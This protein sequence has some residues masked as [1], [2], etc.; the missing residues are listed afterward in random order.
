MHTR[1]RLSGVTASLTCLGLGLAMTSAAAFAAND[2]EVIFTKIPGHPSSVIPGAL[3]LDGL[4]AFAEFRHMNQL[5]GSPDGS[6]WLMTAR[7]QQGSELETLLM[8]GDGADGSV[9]AQKNQPVH[10]GVPGEVYDFF[11]SGVGRFNDNNDFAFSARAMNGVA[12]H[13]QKVI[14]VIAGNAEIVLQQGDPYFGLEDVPGNPS[15]DELVGNSVGSVH[16]LNDG[17][18]GVHDNTIQNIHSSRRPA[19]FYD[20][21]MFHQT[22]VT[23][24][25]G[26]DGETLF[27]WDTISFNTFYTT[28]N[29]SPISLG[30]NDDERW[31]AHGRRSEQPLPDRVF[32]VDGQIVLETGEQI[33]GEPNVVENIFS[34]DL[35]SN[36]DWYVRGDS[37]GG[38]RVWAIRNGQVVARTSDPIP[39][40][41]ERW[42]TSFVHF[43]GNNHGD[44]M[45]IG[46]TDHP[47]NTRD[48]VIVVNGDVVV[49]SGD[50]ID[51]SGNGLFDDDVFIGRNNPDAA[52]FNGQAF[53]SDDGYVYFFAMLRDSEGNEYNTNPPFSTP[54]SFLRVKVDPTPTC[55][56]DLN[57][58]GVVNVSDLLQL[59]GVWGPCTD[60]V[61]DITG[62]GVVDVSDLLLL[63]SN[64]GECD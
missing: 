6:R 38:T 15:G 27:T 25:V 57:N 61:E 50:P 37:D 46:K 11:G 19:L 41:T 1:P 5:V 29:T 31:I 10:G 21:I 12:A 23:D 39:G 55:E 9:F 54:V 63:L 14:R 42:A 62:D 64:W 33:P 52:S 49:R 53:L 56:G 22:N 35:V 17:T 32:V 44:W 2:I 40:T 8:L 24:I 51:L 45:L 4:P 36:G 16:L 58:D 60:C 20:A 28:P 18:I 26:L 7:S 48:E 30:E 3:D 34:S 59:L 47:D 13:A 43:T